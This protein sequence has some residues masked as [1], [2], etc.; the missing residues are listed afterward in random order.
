MLS[1]PSAALD[2]T[3]YLQDGTYKN[4]KKTINDLEKN[5]EVYASLN[6]IYHGLLG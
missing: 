5:T 2:C 1:F 3:T 6:L 4:L